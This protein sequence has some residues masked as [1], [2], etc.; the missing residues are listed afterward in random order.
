MEQRISIATLAATDVARLAAFYERL[1]W[2]SGFRNDEVAFFQLN[3]IVLGLWQREAFATELGI[4]PDALRPGGT[5]LGHNVR[6]R[7]AVDEVLAA[8]AQAGADIAQPAKDAP[9]GGRSGHFRDPDGF[10]WEVA[11]NPAWPIA[12]DGSVQ[13]G[14]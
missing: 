1:G 7:E 3:G 10:L 8:A 4:D 5:A 6:T 9:W 13:L 12:A 14:I 2:Q 11:W